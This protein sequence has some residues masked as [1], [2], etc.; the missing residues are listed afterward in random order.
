MLDEEYSRLPQPSND[1]NCST[2]TA[3][4][5]MQ[6][7]FPRLEFGLLVGTAGGDPKQTDAGHI[8][9]GDI[10][11]SQS[12]GQQSGVVQHDH[13]KALVGKF[14]RTGC[15]APPPKALLHAASELEMTRARLGRDPFQANLRRIDIA[16]TDLRKYE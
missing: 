5:H 7:T 6:R 16:K 14:L 1:S 13:G 3:V 9:L 4:A 10:V 11:V 12:A 8:R 15:L 2:A